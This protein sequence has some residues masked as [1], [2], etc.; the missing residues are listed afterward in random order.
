M[1]WICPT[2]KRKLKGP[3][4][5]HSCFISDKEYHLKRMNENVRDVFYS[6]LSHLQSFEGI[7]IIYL[8]TCIQFKTVSTFLSIYTKRDRL[9]LEFQLGREDDYFPIYKCQR[10]SKN[11]VLHRLAIG[12]LSDFDEQVKLW[13]RDTYY[14]ISKM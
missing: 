1:I 9:E 12:E 6:L 8:K 5:Y 10:I 3:N 4:Q 13:I 7:E 14:L 2:C 11:R